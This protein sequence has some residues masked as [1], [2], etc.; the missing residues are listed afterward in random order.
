MQ[1]IKN[2]IKW[3]KE[4]GI[5]TKGFFIIGNPSES[6]EDIEMT[7]R[8][9]LDIDLDDILVEYF[10]PYPG[11]EAYKEIKDYGTFNSNWEALNTFSVSF[12]PHGLTHDYLK[13]QFK[14][15]YRSFYF[16]PKIILNYIIRLGSLRK[17]FPL[18]MKFIRFLFFN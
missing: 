3:A 6:K 8:I 9:M 12:L 17:I 14:A 10:T 5:S 7:R 15:S 18:L 4:S 13:K 11:T 16:R 2:A 1:Q